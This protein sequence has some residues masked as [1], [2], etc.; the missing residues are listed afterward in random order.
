MKLHRF[1]FLLPLI[2]FVLVGCAPSPPPR[3]EVA[4]PPPP[5]P[6]PQ[7]YVFHK[8]MPG[9]TFATIAKWYS[10]KESNWHEIAEHNQELNP[11][12]LRVG[13]VVKV[14]V[15]LTTVHNIQPN[16]STAPRKVKKK[17]APG[18]P[19]EEEELPPGPEEV[20]GPK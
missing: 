11:G 7:A 12:S 15:Y 10:G 2:A 14:P 19:V 4:V 13:D 9:E 17:A 16:F 3:E 5:G 20:F 1:L 8:I 18:K 6:P